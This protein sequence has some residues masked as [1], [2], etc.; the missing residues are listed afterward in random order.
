VTEELGNLTLNREEID[1]DPLVP[2]SGCLRLSYVFAC[3]YFVLSQVMSWA[4]YLV[5]C[6]LLS[7]CNL[8]GGYFN[9]AWEPSA[10]NEIKKILRY[11]A[12]DFFVF[13]RNIDHVFKNMTQ[14]KRARPF[15]KAYSLQGPKFSQKRSERKRLQSELFTKNGEVFVAA[16]MRNGIAV[17]ITPSIGF[18]P[19]KCSASIILRNGFYLSKLRCTELRSNIT[20]IQFIMGLLNH[21]HDRHKKL[22]E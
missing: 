15:K 1:R 5:A 9:N 19:Y 7:A 16:F 8:V 2:V 3:Y 6:M 11:V 13:A 18:R 21:C 4:I 20:I 12:K 10:K 17:R 14:G 22:Q